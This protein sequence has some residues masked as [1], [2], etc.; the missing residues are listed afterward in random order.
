MR[1]SCER[2]R[3]KFSPWIFETGDMVYNICP[4][5]YYKAVNQRE[6]DIQKLVE[7]TID[8][9]GMKVGIGVYNKLM[10]PEKEKKK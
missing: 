7:T 5:C 2:C 6:L 3:S 1:K 9:H 4:S 8:E 10:Y